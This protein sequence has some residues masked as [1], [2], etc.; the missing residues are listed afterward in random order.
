MACDVTHLAE[1]QCECLFYF[2]RGVFFFLS[3]AKSIFFIFIFH[4]IL[5]IYH[6][7]K[8]CFLLDWA[9]KVGIIG[10]KTVNIML[11]PYELVKYM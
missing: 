5:Q 8:F 3:L 1:L 2:D 4:Y 6:L 9:L 10:L 7:I 11:W